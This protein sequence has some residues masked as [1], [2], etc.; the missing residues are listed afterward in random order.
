MSSWECGKCHRSYKGST[1]LAAVICPECGELMSKIGTI[2]DTEASPTLLFRG[3]GWTERAI[4]F[5]DSK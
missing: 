1:K 2:N 3:R 5:T 4:R